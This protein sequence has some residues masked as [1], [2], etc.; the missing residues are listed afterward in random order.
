[1]SNFDSR[2]FVDALREGA[3]LL[4]TLLTAVPPDHRPV[5]PRPEKWSAL[6]ILAHLV[7][8]EREDFRRRLRLTL[9]D[10]TADWP[11]IDPEGWVTERDYASRDFDTLLGELRHERAESLDWLASL[12]APDWS[13]AH[14][15]PALG[16]LRAGDLLCAWAAHDHLH[17]RQILRTR[18]ELLEG[19]TGE[20]S[21]R[22]AM[23]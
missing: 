10:P 1:M 18:W 20:F 11:P 14:E 3:T 5:R 2:S 8:E 6:E 22:Y 23:P 21:A 19:Q 7:D 9:E 12:S 16:T 17:A 15:H 4:P 13:T